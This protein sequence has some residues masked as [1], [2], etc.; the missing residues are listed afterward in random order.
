MSM[1]KSKT[2]SWISLFG[3]RAMAIFKCFIS[4]DK[5]LTLL[6]AIEIARS[7]EVT[8]KHMKMLVGGSKSHQED[9][10]INAILKE[11]EREFCH[12][13]RKQH[14]RGKCSAYGT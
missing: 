3:D 14:P 1:L 5:S 8:S 11:Q 10:G 13:C 12:N 6:V 4:Q 9:R 2:V 7:H